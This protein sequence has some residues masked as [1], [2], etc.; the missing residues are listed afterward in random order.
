MSRE[1]VA[2]TPPPQASPKAALDVRPSRVYG[3]LAVSLVVTSLTTYIL[4]TN[5]QRL[6]RW[7]L[8]EKL[9]SIAAVAALQFSPSELDQIRA[10]AL[11]PEKFHR[12][13]SDSMWRNW[14]RGHV[15]YINRLLPTVN[16]IPSALL[17]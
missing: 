1:K 17:Q 2:A 6:F 7:S 10:D 4:Y 3:L 15:D 13:Y 11:P 16:T 5:T 8:E 9:R 14:R 12:C